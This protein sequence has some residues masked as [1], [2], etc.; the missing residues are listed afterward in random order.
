[1]RA[2]NQLRTQPAS[3][4]VLKARD[5]QLF[6]FCGLAMCSTFGGESMRWHAVHCPGG[7]VITIAF[8][9]EIFCMQACGISRAIGKA[10][11]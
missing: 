9:L 11:A 1:M 10:A 3:A 4:I 8:V 7:G 6:D 5:K 2:A